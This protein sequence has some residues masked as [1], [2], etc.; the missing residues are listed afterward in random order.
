M[1]YAF[2]DPR[3]PGPYK[4]DPPPDPRA[5]AVHA[6]RARNRYG[7]SA[8]FRMHLHTAVLYSQL[9]V[10]QSGWFCLY[11]FGRLNT[12]KGFIP[13]ETNGTLLLCLR[14]PSVCL[15]ADRTF[16]RDR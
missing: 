11:Y 10:V 13:K 15:S 5:V 16:Y 9:A 7:R 4:P 8:A 1:K 2:L 3:A 6:A 14:W 12:K